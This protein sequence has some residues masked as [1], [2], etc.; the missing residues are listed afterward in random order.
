[1]LGPTARGAKTET[2]ESLETHGWLRA[3]DGRRLVGGCRWFE[4]WEQKGDHPLRYF[5]EPAYL[6]MR[7]TGLPAVLE[8]S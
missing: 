7:H 2:A 5:L 4:Q 3:S 8:Y 1:M 6:T